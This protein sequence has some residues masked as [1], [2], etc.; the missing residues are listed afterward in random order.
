M[1]G[2]RVDLV[3]VVS[4][5]APAPKETEVAEE[6]QDNL[7]YLVRKERLDI[8]GHLALK[9]R[10]ENPE[11]NVRWC[12]T[13]KTNALAAMVPRSAL[14]SQPSWPSLLTPPQAL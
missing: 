9:A 3:T 4:L 6:T 8:L 13:S 12:G 14:S 2:Q 5:E 7:G 11:I 1:Q 10:K